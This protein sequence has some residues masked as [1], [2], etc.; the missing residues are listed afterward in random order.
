MPWSDSCSR[1]PKGMLS[2]WS[3]RIEPHE[4]HWL[5]VCPEVLVEGQGVLNSG[6]K[7]HSAFSASATKALGKQQ[8]KHHLNEANEGCCVPWVTGRFYRRNK[9]MLPLTEGLLVG[10]SLTKTCDFLPSPHSVK[11][12]KPNLLKQSTNQLLLDKQ[13]SL[14][15]GLSEYPAP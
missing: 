4:P 12:S 2:S 14:Q 15:K 11:V 13:L 1:R 6:R 8:G 7:T 10:R 9:S 5:W 3:Q